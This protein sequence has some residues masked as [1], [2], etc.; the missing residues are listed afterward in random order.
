M[1]RLPRECGQRR[2]L[3]RVWEATWCEMSSIC[4]IK[5]ALSQDGETDAVVGWRV[6]SL[7]RSATWE[8]EAKLSLAWPASRAWM[9][10][11]S[12]LDH[13]LRRNSSDTSGARI[14]RCRKTRIFCFYPYPGVEGVGEYFG[15]EKWT[16]AT[17][18]PSSLSDRARVPKGKVMTSSISATC[19]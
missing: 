2:L 16:T 7:I 8:A 14:L 3:C 13:M 6:T 9:S 12:L 19:R 5:L 11:R 1:L 17:L 10:E 4:W 18:T 15:R